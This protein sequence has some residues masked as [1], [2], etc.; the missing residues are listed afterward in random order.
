MVSA[1]RLQQDR[2]PVKIQKLLLATR[3]PSHINNFYGVN[4]HPLERGTVSYWR[5]NEVSVVLKANEPAIEK[6]IDTRRQKQAILAV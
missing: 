5:N 4:A 6:M 1:V 3:E 2:A